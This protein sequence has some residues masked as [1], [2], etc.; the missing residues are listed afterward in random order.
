MRRGVTLLELALALAIMGLLF[1]IALPKLRQIADHLAVQNA[2][3]ELVSAHRR[4]RM[5]SIVQSRL[6]QLDIR[7]DTIAIRLPGRPDH[8]WHTA[9][10][11]ADGVALTGPARGL[12]F[13]PVGITVGVSNGS[14]RLS[15]G[16]ASRTV[17]VSRLGRVRIVP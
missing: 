6:L 13:S 16:A 12:I 5:S 14:F 9:G 2:A 11:A 1:G 10:P 3:L 17:I 8:L 4:A 7:A 15:R